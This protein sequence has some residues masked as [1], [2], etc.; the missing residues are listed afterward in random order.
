[1]A[2][3]RVPDIDGKRKCSKCGVVKILD[4]FTKNPNCLN[5]RERKCKE[6]TQKSRKTPEQIAS[7]RRLGREWYERNKDLTKYRAAQYAKE[8]PEVIAATMHRR[9]MRAVANGNNDLTSEQIKNLFQAITSCIY[10]NSKENLTLEHLTPI[11]RG[12]Q[13][14]L[15]NVSVSCRPC[16]NK[17]RTLT[18]EEY[19]NERNLSRS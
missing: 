10:C 14:T 16:N 7:Q 13:N 4:E 8:H 12:G 15:N 18:H 5:G 3:V 2:K 9:R 1:M 19:M 6:C 17:K 11:S